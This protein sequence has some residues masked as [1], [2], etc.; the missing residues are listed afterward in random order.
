MITLWHN[1]RC[2]KSRAAQALLEGQDVTLRL[3][4]KDAPGEAELRAAHALLGGQVIDMMRPNEA[5]F[6]EA[7]LTRGSSDDALFAAMAAHPILIERPLALSGNRAVIGRPP[8]AVL[9][10]LAR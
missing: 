7:G 6:R 4:L 1:P 10:L 2:A 8:E 5:A 3:Y 9:T